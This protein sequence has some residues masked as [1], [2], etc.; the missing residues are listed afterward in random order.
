MLT[1]SPALIPVVAINVIMPKSRFPE[2]IAA[3]HMARRSSGLI[4]FISTGRVSLGALRW[5]TGLTSASRCGQQESI[6]RGKAHPHPLSSIAA[7]FWTLAIC[8]RTRRPFAQDKAPQFVHLHL[9]HFHLAQQVLVDLIGFLRC[10]SQPF[11][12]RLFRHSQGKADG[13]QL[14]LAQQQLEH[15]HHLLFRCAQIIEDRFPRLRKLL[16]TRSALEDAPLPTLGLVRRYRLHVAA[17][18]QFIMVT[19][20]VGARLSPVFWLSHEV[21]FHQVRS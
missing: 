8:C 17:P 11:Q 10:T 12:T 3:R 13:T 4:A 20:R 1:N 14:H 6:F 7:F 16:S 5:S 15:D 2:S 9:G 18:H 21:A 19:G